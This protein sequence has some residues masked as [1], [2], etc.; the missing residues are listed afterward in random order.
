VKEVEEDG[1]KARDPKR[2]P[3]SSKSV[4]TQ[5]DRPFIAMVINCTAEMECKITENIC[6]GRCKEVL[7]GCIRFDLRRV[8]GCVAW[9]CP[10][11]PGRWHY[12]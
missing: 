3:M 10:V 6:C 1:S 5:R 4:S 11:L 9:W 8:T 2:I 7:V 12:V